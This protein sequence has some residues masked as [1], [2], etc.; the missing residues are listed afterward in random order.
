M[1]WYLIFT[2][3]FQFVIKIQVIL[4][5]PFPLEKN[6][7][8]GPLTRHWSSWQRKA[9]VGVYDEFWI[10][11]E[12]SPPHYQRAA[13]T[14]PPLLCPELCGICFAL[15]QKNTGK[16]YSHFSSSLSP[17]LR[18]NAPF[19]LPSLCAAQAILRTLNNNTS[20]YLWFVQCVTSSR[21]KQTAAFPK[22]WIVFKKFRLASCL[23][24]PS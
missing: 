16:F 12:I 1:H 11:G 22:T 3:G 10:Q 7:P 15:P 24:S 21:T 19:S 20:P 14:L 2:F 5:L 4:C 13:L 23:E 8:F 17:G 9:E 6:C 18:G